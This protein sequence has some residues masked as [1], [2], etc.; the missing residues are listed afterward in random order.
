MVM[1]SHSLPMRPF[2]RSIMPLV[3]GVLGQ[4]WQYSVPPNEISNTAGKKRTNLERSG[5][6]LSTIDHQNLAR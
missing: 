5:L 4:A 1:A 6:F 2:K 3:Y